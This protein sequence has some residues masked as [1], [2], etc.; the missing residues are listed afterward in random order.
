MIN[1]SYCR[2]SN[3]ALALEECVDD[4]ENYGINNLSKDESAAAISIYELAKKF[5]K[6]YDESN[7]KTN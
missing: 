6:L 2:F 1:M 4:L 7:E 5:I 3:T